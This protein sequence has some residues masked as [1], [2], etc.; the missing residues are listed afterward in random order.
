MLFVAVLDCDYLI[1]GISNLSF[2]YSI[3][4]YTFLGYNINDRRK[5]ID[6]R[7][8]DGHPRGYLRNEEWKKS[9]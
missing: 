2:I 7:Y 6:R 4:V 1:S 5:K 9:T 3:D 8:V